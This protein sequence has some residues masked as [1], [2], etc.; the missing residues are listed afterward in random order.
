M[1]QSKLQENERADLVMAIRL[2]FPNT[3]RRVFALRGM[4]PAVP[5]PLGWDRAKWALEGDDA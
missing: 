1:T 4:D 5:D 2:A 3:W